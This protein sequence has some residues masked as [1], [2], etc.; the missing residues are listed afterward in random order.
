M[1]IS[2][3]ALASLRSG[4]PSA[5]SQLFCGLEWDMTFQKEL[6][7]RV[8]RESAER[9]ANH[10]IEVLRDDGMYRHFRCRNH[11]SSIDGFDVVTWPGSLCYTGDMGNYLFQRT[12]DMIAFMRRS[13]MSFDYAAEKCVAFDRDGVREFR[14]EVFD[15][16]LAD[17]AEEMKATVEDDDAA[18][19]LA[20]M[21]EKIEE[22]QTAYEEYGAPHDGLRA[23]YESGLYD[24]CDTPS[25][26]S[27][28]YR[29]LFCCHAI[30]W[31]CER[32]AVA[33][34]AA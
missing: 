24:G 28:T 6:E 19:Q 8:A 32:L 12:E 2:Q 23:M 33:S 17:L 9:L 27:F 34:A 25:C 1:T 20:A 21:E 30:K 11:G 15:E 3:N 4:R 10:T 26:E 13:C 22:I 29:F 16:H 7:Q 18:D 14:R 5:D 31:L